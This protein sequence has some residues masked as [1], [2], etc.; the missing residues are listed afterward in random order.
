[1]LYDTGYK[2][3]T[4]LR[5]RQQMFGFDQS[6]QKGVK[7]M[8][9]ASDGSCFP[10]SSSPLPKIPEKLLW[11]RFSPHEK[12]ATLSSVIYSPSCS[13]LFIIFQG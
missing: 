6:K 8:T 7:T 9:G 11:I 10:L 12:S 2:F 1:M 13:K 5:S 4:S 3:K